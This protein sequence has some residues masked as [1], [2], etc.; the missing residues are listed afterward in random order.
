MHFS[1]K[2]ILQSRKYFNDCPQEKKQNKAAVGQYAQT[3]QKQSFRSV[4]ILQHW[5]A[6]TLRNR[7][8]MYSDPCQSHSPQGQSLKTGTAKTKD[9]TS[10]NNSWSQKV[11][12]WGKQ[13]F[14][15]ISISV[16]ELYMCVHACFIWQTH[17]PLCRLLLADKPKTLASPGEVQQYHLLHCGC[18]EKSVHTTERYN[19]SERRRLLVHQHT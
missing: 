1:D 11:I 8:V 9:S 5:C 18:R 2:Q 10:P 15:C 16:H 7:M 4:S 12:V 14:I 6:S 3:P 13:T 19:K 17:S